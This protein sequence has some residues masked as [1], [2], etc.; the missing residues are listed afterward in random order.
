MNIWIYLYY[1]ELR[2]RKRNIWFPNSRKKKNT[3]QI[4][5]YLCYTWNWS[6]PKKNTKIINIVQDG[7]KYTGLN[8]L[9]LGKF[10][11]DRDEQES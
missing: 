4:C 6:K 7:L 5:K 9:N 1:K 3:I 10:S 8:C 11:Q 2:K